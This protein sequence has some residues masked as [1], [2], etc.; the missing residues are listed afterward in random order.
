MQASQW[1]G[2]AAVYSLAGGR[3]SWCLRLP[4]TVLAV[5][6]RSSQLA[7]GTHPASVVMMDGSGALVRGLGLLRGLRLQAARFYQAQQ[8]ADLVRCKG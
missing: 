5:D 3:L 4:V 8:K 6:A 7:L 2:G 1:D